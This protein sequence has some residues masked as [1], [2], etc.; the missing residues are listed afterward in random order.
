MPQE[1]LKAL[2]KE[3]FGCYVRRVGGEAVHEVSLTGVEW[4]GTVAVFELVGHPDSDTAYA[5][6]YVQRGRRKTMLVLKIP[7]VD[8]ARIAV[9]MAISRKARAT[10]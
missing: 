7:P 10:D 9:K 1:S 6:E 5:W 8:S 4:R 3:R 2:I